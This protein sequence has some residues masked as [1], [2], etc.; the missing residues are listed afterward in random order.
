MGRRG[1]PQTFCLAPELHSVS[2]QPSPSAV[3]PRIGYIGLGDMG[4]AMVWNLAQKGWR[5][6]IYA[7]RQASLVPFLEQDVQIV[8][9]PTDVGAAC[10]LLCL[11]VVD[12]D[13]VAQVLFGERGA[14]RAL[15]PGSVVVLHSTLP[16]EECREMA[17][18]LAL[19]RIDLIDAPVSGA[20]G[21]ARKGELSISVGG[22]ARVVKRCL[23]L[24]EAE[25]SSVLYMGETGSGQAA[26]LFNNALFFVQLS[27]VDEA[28][29]LGRG[30]GLSDEKLLELINSGSAASWASERF[31]KIRAKGG[32]L[33]DDHDTSYPGGLRAIVQKDMS[34]FARQFG[35]D[36]LTKPRLADL[37]QGVVE[38]FDREPT[39]TARAGKRK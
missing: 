6:V 22:P 37:A 13:Q 3:R 14:V 1:F 33:F 2:R 25:A 19:L 26:K 4:A 5:P 23:P 39:S 21:R 20:A 16:P 34:A 29:K 8:A 35:D 31:A 18:R 24:L 27:L 32:S 11:C 10:D 9:S 15:R 36:D 12:A 17:K 38:A 30:M 7:R 28:V